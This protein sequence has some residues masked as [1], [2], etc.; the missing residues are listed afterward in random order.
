MD[1][2]EEED[3]SKDGR[4]QNKEPRIAIEGMRMLKGKKSN[5]MLF[6]TSKEDKS[7]DE[8]S[9]ESEF[10]DSN[11]EMKRAEAVLSEQM[12]EALSPLIDS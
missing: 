8:E 3:N 2:S 12:E 9:K 4:Q 6:E 1:E 7:G 5:A 11:D 10:E